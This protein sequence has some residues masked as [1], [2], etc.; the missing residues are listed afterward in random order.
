MDFQKLLVEGTHFFNFPRENIFGAF[1]GF[2]FLFFVGNH[3][4]FGQPGFRGVIFVC[5]VVGF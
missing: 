3:V 1:F 4:L 5:I 2:S